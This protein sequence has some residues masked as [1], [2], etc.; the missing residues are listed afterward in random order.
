MVK[1]YLPLCAIHYHQCV[2][3]KPPEVELK[4]DL[5]KA[6]F[7]TTTQM[8]DYPK[9]VPKNRFPLPKSE[10]PATT[11][12][13]LVSFGLP[14]AVIGYATTLTQPVELLSAA[15]VSAPLPSLLED[16]SGDITLT[17]P[18]L[19]GQ[20]H[21]DNVASITFYVDSGAGQCLCSCS[22]AFITMQTCHIQVVG[23]AGRLNI[24][25][26]GTAVFLVSVSVD[27]QDALLCIH[28]CLHSYG[29]FNLLSVSQLKLVSGNSLDLSV[30]APFLRFSR[31]QLKCRD[32]SDSNCFEVPLHIEDALFALHLEPVTPN[33]PRFR[34]LPIFDV[35][36]PRT[37][38]S[39]HSATQCCCCI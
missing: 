11:R 29:E 37:I 32:L 26:H 8:V 31:D 20:S 25:G 5:G 14:S 2:S 3:G 38:R 24:H 16:S 15:S 6:K 35:T 21:V 13:A 34:D 12:K 30:E 22:S 27:G 7:N 9:T 18:L 1:E 17:V 23:V 39:G 10:R 4:D 36:P 19:L 33:D 28:N